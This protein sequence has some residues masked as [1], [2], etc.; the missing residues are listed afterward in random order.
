MSSESNSTVSEHH[1]EDVLP[2]D[3]DAKRKNLVYEV[4]GRLT[5]QQR[6]TFEFADDVIASVKDMVVQVDEYG[7]ETEYVYVQIVR[8]DS[9]CYQE[10]LNFVNNKEI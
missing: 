4:S 9:D 6:K 3:T 8:K 10:L 1:E 2:I 5:P 7:V